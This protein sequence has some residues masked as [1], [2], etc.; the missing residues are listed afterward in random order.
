MPSIDSPTDTIIE[1]AGVEKQ[2]DGPSSAIIDATF[3]EQEIKG[4]GDLTLE[5]GTA[6]GM[7]RHLGVFSCTMLMYA[8]SGDPFTLY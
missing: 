6:G 8:P 2:V 1:T 3:S 7:G 5:E 4:P